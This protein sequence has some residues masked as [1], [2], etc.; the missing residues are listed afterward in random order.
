M[1]IKLNQ[2]DPVDVLAKL[3]RE[4]WQELTTS[5]EQLQRQKH[6]E[7]VTLS[8]L[9]V[10]GVCDLF[11]YLLNSHKHEVNNHLEFLIYLP[12]G[13]PLPTHP[14]PQTLIGFKR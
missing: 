13:H 14:P 7:K 8:T 10:S 12:R 1:F 6:R 9:I 4:K 11:N 5:P 2:P 3:V